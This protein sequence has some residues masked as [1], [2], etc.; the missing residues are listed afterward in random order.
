MGPKKRE[1]SDVSELVHVRPPPC[2]FCQ[3]DP[4]ATKARES[5]IR[6]N[7]PSDLLSYLEREDLRKTPRELLAQ[8]A[9]RNAIPPTTAQKL[10]DSYDSFLGVLDDQRRDHLER[11]SHDDME[12]SGVWQEIREMSHQFQSGLNEL[13]YGPDEQLRQ[14]M[15]SYEVFLMRPIGFSTGAI[16]K[17]HYRQALNKLIQS[18]VR[19]VEL[20]A[21]RRWELPPLIADI[22]SLPLSNFD[23]VS[24]HAP[25]SFDAAEDAVISQLDR[26]A[27]LGMPII[28]HPDVIVSSADWKHFGSLL[29]IENMDKRKANGRTAADLAALFDRFPVA[30][31]CFD[32]GHARQVDPTML[33]AARILEQHGDR[34]AQV[35][36]SEVNTASRHDPISEYAIQAFRSVAH[37]IP[38]R[39]PIISETL[40][41]RGQSSIP[42]ELRRAAEGVRA[43]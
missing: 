43:R 11:L 2:F 10:F 37:L 30:R 14:L 40:I 39:T 31:M 33:E 19:V 23:F 9:S 20:S 18:Q 7:D 27:A 1:A 13:F 28:V 6:G 25:S 35:H 12:H 22:Q 4:I 15:I 17:A 29:V 24:V 21:L 26:I 36:I 38:E 8:A 32:L 5:L 3:L 34:L 42:K 41:D 16:A